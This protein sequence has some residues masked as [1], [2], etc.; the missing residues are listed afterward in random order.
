MANTSEV[1]KERTTQALYKTTYKKT[2]MHNH[3]TRTWSL[4]FPEALKK[5]P[6]QSP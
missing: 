5:T 6:N 3:K 1:I 4:H 2:L